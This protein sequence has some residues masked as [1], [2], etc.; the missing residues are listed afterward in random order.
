MRCATDSLADGELGDRVAGIVEGCSEYLA[1]PD[2]ETP[3]R[4]TWR[5]STTL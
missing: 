5:L 4:L 1:V 3:P 2:T